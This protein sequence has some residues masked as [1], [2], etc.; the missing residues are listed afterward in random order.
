MVEIEE[1]R[2]LDE[3][4]AVAHLAPSVRDLREE[5]SRVVPRLKGRT[6]W[7]V[8]STSRG[9]G[10]AEM[11]PTMVT[12]LRELGVSTEW[13]TIESEDPDFF[14]LTKRLQGDGS[15]L[16]ANMW[17]DIGL[18]TRPIVTQ[19]S[20]WDRLKGFKPLMDAFVRMKLAIFDRRENQGWEERRRMDLVRLA[21]TRRRSRTTRRARRCWKS[22]TQRTSSSIRHSRTTW[23]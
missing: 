18:L 2:T 8:N 10:V 12:L 5:A 1:R 19:V 22:F 16:P 20:R 3:Y 13:V 21:P 15:Y 6:V 7:M 11:L 4:E 9:G 14:A 17:E 23:P